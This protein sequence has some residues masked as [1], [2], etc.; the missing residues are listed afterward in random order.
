MNLLTD[1]LPSSV[2]AGGRDYPVNTGFKTWVQFDFLMTESDLPL[3]QKLAQVFQLC[4]VEKTL[5]PDL[6]T[7]LTALFDFYSCMSSAQKSGSEKKKDAPA[8]RVLSFSHD[9]PFIYAAFL[10]QYGVDLVAENP[11]WFLFRAMFDS[12][13]K[14]HKICDIMHYRSVKLS[15]VKDAKQRA[16]YRKMKGIYM[17]P[18]NRTPEEIERDTIRNLA[19]II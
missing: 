18:D 16:F 11:H 10:A 2:S 4:F 5:P 1:P 13:G 12:L 6:E 7:A 15:D 8:R 9:A 14:E 17:L 19:K 3:P